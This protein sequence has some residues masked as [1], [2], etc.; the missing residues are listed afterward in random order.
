MASLTSP[1][2]FL[3]ECV[4]QTEPNSIICARRPDVN[5]VLERSGGYRLW[6]PGYYCPF[7][8][9]EGLPFLMTI[10]GSA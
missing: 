8:P 5:D 2:R 3:I 1:G 4:A 6:P 9:R 7:P 10:P